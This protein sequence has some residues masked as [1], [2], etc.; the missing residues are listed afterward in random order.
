MPLEYDYSGKPHTDPAKAESGQSIRSA[1]K[2]GGEGIAAWGG[3]QT[4]ETLED[5]DKEKDITLP[6]EPLRSADGKG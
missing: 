6:E 1:P 5:A 2:Y 3:F 4:A